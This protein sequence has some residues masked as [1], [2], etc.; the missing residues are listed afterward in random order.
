M[1][2]GREGD[3][4]LIRQVVR[5]E[6][7][8]TDLG[9][10]GISIRLDGSRCTV[11][12]PRGILAVADAHDLAK[13]FLG[14]SRDAHELQKWA[15]VMEASSP[16][17]DLDVEQHP[18]GETLLSALW[19]ASFGEPIPDEVLRTVEQIAGANQSQV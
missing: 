18:A 15:Y 3:E 11:E 1:S 19:S 2:T 12:N 7:P 10:I 14:Y 17:L 16:F 6:R 8:W 9:A 5:G 13:G 4:A